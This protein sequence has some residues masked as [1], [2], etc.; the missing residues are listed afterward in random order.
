MTVLT[1]FVFPSVRLIALVRPHY[2]SGGICGF[3]PDDYGSLAR[4]LTV[5]PQLLQFR[6]ALHI[7]FARNANLMRG[8]VLIP[9]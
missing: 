8:L 9:V 6:G 3:T 4:N 1:V 7:E 2:S 5:M